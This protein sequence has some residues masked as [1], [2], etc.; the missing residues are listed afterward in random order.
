MV[1]NIITNDYRSKPAPGFVAFCI[2]QEYY[3][4][5]I[6]NSL[7]FAVKTPWCNNRL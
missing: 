3:A 1:L 5:A 6:Y 4:L 2:T 7:Q